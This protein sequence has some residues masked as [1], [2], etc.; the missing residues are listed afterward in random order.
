ME[1][2]NNEWEQERASILNTK[3]STRKLQ[4]TSTKELLDIITTGAS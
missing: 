4:V 3:I 1:V 2:F